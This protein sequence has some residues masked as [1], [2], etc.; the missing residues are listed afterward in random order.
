VKDEIKRNYDPWSG[1]SKDEDPSPKAKLIYR[2]LAKRRSE[3]IWKKQLK[4]EN[5]QCH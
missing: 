5:K 3:R 1:Y 2:R 4:K